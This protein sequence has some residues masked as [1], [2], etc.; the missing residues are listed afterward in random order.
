MVTEFLW[1]NLS[2]NEFVE[3]DTLSK[4]VNNIYIKKCSTQ[5]TNELWSQTT[6]CATLIRMKYI[7]C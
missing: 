2:F 7:T 4:Q 1:A 5:Q 3:L 6:H